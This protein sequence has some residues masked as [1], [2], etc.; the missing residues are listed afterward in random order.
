VRTFYSLM[1][2]ALLFTAVAAATDIPRYEAYLGFQYVRAN[3][4]NQNTGLGQ[5]IGGF[6]MYGGDGQFV[7]NYNRWISGVVDGGAVNKPNVGIVNVQNTTA[8]VYAGP[9][10]YYRKYHGV[11]PF[12]QCLFGAAFRRVSTEVTA[13]TSPNTPNFPVASLG[14]LFPGPLTVVNARLTGSENAFSMKVGG[15][16]DYRLGKHFSLRPVEVDYVLTRFPS[17]TDGTRQNQSSIAATA[18]IIFTF[19]AE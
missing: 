18:G 3:Q 4:F 10:F 16:L 1:G 6:D 11:S 14:N 9:R 17:L 15:G 2:V 7:Y 13:L 8:F 5:T 12:A 19:G